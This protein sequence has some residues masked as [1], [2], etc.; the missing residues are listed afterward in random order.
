MAL[1]DI[2]LRY[3]V[4]AVF[5]LFS[6]VLVAMSL[7]SLFLIAS[8]TS[9]AL[10]YTLPNH[11]SPAPPSTL[12]V[13][14]NGTFQI[15]VFEDL[16]F[17]EAEDTLWGPQQDVDSIRVMNSV[18]A[19][20]T[21]QLVVLNGDLITGENT[22]LANSTHYVDQIVQ[23]LVE[24]GLPWASTYGNHDSDFNLSRAGIF[25][26][27]KRFPGSLTQN[28]VKSSSA[29]ITNYYLPVYG[30][31][32]AA[33]AFLLWFFD[34]RGGNYFQ[35]TNPSTGDAVPQPNWVD[36]SVV[37]WF[38]STRDELARK[39]GCS[40][41]S[42]AFVHIPV[43]AMLAFQDQGVDANKEPGIN[44]DVPLAAQGSTD[45]QGT[46]SGHGLSYAGQDVPFMKALLETEGLMAVFSG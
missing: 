6:L 44:D 37:N 30:A 36:Q 17:G 15:S 12:H 29:G 16:H 1:R 10:A 42:V 18:L 13:S 40:V 33:P 2:K 4:Q 25:K 5:S 32:T 41:P 39:Y 38:S 46:G 3:A 7:R 43:T 26:R 21:Q 20:E 14:R 31:N 28:M 23:P 34:S 11:P 24:R 27:E 9:A 35:Q 8:S 22:Y 45:G 19:S